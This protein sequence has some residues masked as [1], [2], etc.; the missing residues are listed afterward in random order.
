MINF[1]I[2][3]F[4]FKYASYQDHNV[5]TAAL[6]TLHQLLLSAFASLV[7]KLMTKGITQSS[8]L[9]REH[10]GSTLSL[11]A[12]SNQFVSLYSSFNLTRHLTKI[13]FIGEI[14]SVGSI[15][16]QSDDDIFSGELG[17]KINALRRGSESFPDVSEE[18][19]QKM[20]E[21]WVQEQS[22]NDEDDVSSSSL[23]NMDT[24][25]FANSD[26]G[27]LFYFNARL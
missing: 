18:Q 10:H 8:V 24:S 6:E 22:E 13:H 20:T 23:L 2:Y 26:D 3:E 5:V 11:T 1:Q 16:A 27:L 9:R 14:F 15:I 25:H 17:K 12:R 4:C 21:N 7:E 19:K